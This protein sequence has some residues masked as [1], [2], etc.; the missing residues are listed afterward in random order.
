MFLK[1]ARAFRH[2]KELNNVTNVTKT[3]ETVSF[4]TRLW[5][6]LNASDVKKKDKEFL[7]LKHVWIFTIK[8]R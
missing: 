2:N 8:V 4:N 7:T 5:W 1:V 6:E 3:T